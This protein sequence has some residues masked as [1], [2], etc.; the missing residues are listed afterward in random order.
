MAQTFVTFLSTYGPMLLM[1][2]QT[3]VTCAVAK[4]G[5]FLWIY[6]LNMVFCVGIL[7][8]AGSM[9]LAKTKTAITTGIAKCIALT[10]YVVAR[11]IELFGVLCGVASHGVGKD[12]GC[13]HYRYC[14]VH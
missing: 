9:V 1:L 11:M 5:A 4:F 13:Y 14:Q 7:W 6:F 10:R 3:A 2:I 12:K 8:G